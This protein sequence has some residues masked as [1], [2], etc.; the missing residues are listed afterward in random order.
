MRLI[1]LSLSWI[2]G[3]YLGTWIGFH[4]AAILA[5]AG[6]ALLAFLLRRGQALLLVLCI[7]AVLGGILRFQST[8]PVVDESTLRFYNDE[9]VVQIR[10]LVAADPAPAD[11]T[12]SLLL[13]AREIKIEE[14]WREVS[15]AALVY[16]PRFPSPE[17]FSS[18]G[19]RDPPYYRYGDLVQV[20]GAL[21]TPPGFEDFDWQEYLA[22][23][24]IHSVMRYPHQIELVAGGQGFKPREWLYQLRNSMSRSLD[25]ALHEPQGSLAQAILLGK[26]S[27]IPDD[28]KESFS[29][30]GTAHVVAI[31]GLHIGI[32]GGIVLSF[33]AWLF[34]RRRP[35]YFLLAVG[36]IWGYALLTGLNPPALRAATMV[37]LW[38]FADYVGR[39]RSALTILLFTAALMLGIK[40][41][42]LGEASFQLTFAAMAGLILLTPHFQ[43]LGR[44]IFR[45]TEE[46]RTGVSFLVDSFS[47][48]LGAV[49]ATLPIIAF[50]FHQI[51]F[52]A[53]PANLLVLPA[54]PGIIFATALVGVV[55]L[56]VPPLAA[57]FG[58][59]AWLF[60]SYMVEV[61]EFFSFL[62]FASMEL[63][64]VGASSVWVYYAIMGTGLWIGS[65]RSEV[66]STTGKAIRSLSSLSG[67][68]RS[69]PAKFTVFPLLIVASLVWVAAI[70]A[71]DDRLH[72]FFLD[73]G[74][75]SAILI[76]R[77][78][79]QVLID[80]GPDTERIGLELGDKLPF[81]DRTIE[82]VILTHPEADHITGLVEVL[83]RYEVKQVLTS[84][85]E[86]EAPVYAEWLRLIE[87]KGI[88]RAAARAGQRIELDEEI[89]IEVLHP[90]RDLLR[91]TSSD[92][93]NN[94]V[95]L[96]LV[97]H[98]FSLLL[99]GDIFEEA[100]RHLLAQR[101]SLRSTVLKVA[102]HGSDTSS[103]SE[104]LAGVDPQL[105]IISAGERNRFRHPST[106]VMERLEDVVGEDSIFLTSERG[107]VELITDGERLWVRTEK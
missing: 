22:G 14:E 18:E 100:E 48:T 89:Y 39:P 105:A 82:L 88:D 41:S 97:F 99:T 103:S 61:I 6:V 56:F 44:R 79:Q 50:Y 84:G 85:Q 26:R 69:V 73:V 67:R 60:I 27:T 63:E 28:L 62:P 29:Q 102:H 78:H 9:G 107:T 80:G 57:V 66:R 54:L 92:I 55:G 101:L 35:T 1:Y 93:N 74:Q 16:A 83:R 53:L 21:E 72:V 94:S 104:F 34:G 64:E 87:G 75:G 20:D 17:F 76:Q 58:W 13:E 43:S 7:I 3:I 68:M 10:G 24:G 19:L 2:V 11:S 52:V 25:S 90:Q 45:V 65:N 59:I 86:R 70:T 81:W 49:L 32:L 96:R 95:V 98:D 38:L 91:G 37:S 33:G 46:R 47:I 106:Q 4:W 36:A 12:V 5:V 71:P 15:G 8:V 30:T 31:S 23:K 51:S 77:G 42:V 40:P